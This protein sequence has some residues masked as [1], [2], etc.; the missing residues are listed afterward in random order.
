[1]VIGMSAHRIL[2]FFQ[3][4]A[5]CPSPGIQQTPKPDILTQ[6]VL[7]GKCFIF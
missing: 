7:S 4:N 5:K 2:F 1:M 6:V 3:Q